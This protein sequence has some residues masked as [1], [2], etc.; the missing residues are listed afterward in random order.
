V[1]P[2]RP[3]THDPYCCCPCVVPPR[4]QRFS[5]TVIVARNVDIVT[6]DLTGSRRYTSVNRDS[7]QD[8]LQECSI[9]PQTPVSSQQ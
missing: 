2:M 9:A 7:Q 1:P 8:L 4:V 3:R 6:H 5:P